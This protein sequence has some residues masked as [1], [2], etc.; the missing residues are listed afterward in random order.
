MEEVV[1]EELEPPKL[2]KMLPK[3]P[4]TSPPLHK[5][6]LPMVQRMFWRGDIGLKDLLECI[7]RTRDEDLHTALMPGVDTPVE[8]LDLLP[9]TLPPWYH[10]AMQLVLFGMNK[11]ADADAIAS[12]V[13]SCTTAPGSM[14]GHSPTEVVSDSD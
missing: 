8:E 2:M 4:D 3:E 5:L 6:S 11:L 10:E 9:G 1:I 7:S 12:P 13:E 14:D